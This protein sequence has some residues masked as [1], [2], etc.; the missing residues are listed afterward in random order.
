[1]RSYSRVS[2]QFW[3]G[4]T[5]RALREAGRDV[6]IVALY[7]VTCPSGSMSGV[8][9]L[10]L[11]TLCYEV[12]IS[13]K[14]AQRVLAV[15]ERE[16]FAFFDKASQTVWVPE[17]ARFQIGEQLHPPDKRIRGLGR[18]LEAVAGSP[19]VAQFF[20]RYKEAFHLPEAGPWK[21]FGSP[22]EGPSEPLRSQAQEH[23]QAQEQEHAHEGTRPA[24]RRPAF[25]PPTVKE[26]R[27]YAAE[28]QAKHT[29]PAEF[30][31]YW[32][33]EGWTK[34]NGRKLR[35]WKRAFR[36]RERDLAQRPA[37]WRRPPNAHCTPGRYDDLPS[38]PFVPEGEAS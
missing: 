18:E 7:L 28:I 2:P 15:L 6:Q 17:M 37:G 3:T 1:M 12:G 36:S 20:R 31:T 11:P 9:Y 30:L 34:T 16:R 33:S 24:G 10:P 5:G 25:T 35:D 29:D 23:A 32:E 38:Q 14:K 8:F 4:V 22:S 26:V 27:T 13:R 19:F 21:G